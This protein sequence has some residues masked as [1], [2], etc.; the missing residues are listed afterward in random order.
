MRLKGFIEY[1]PLT[2]I[3][4]N[5]YADQE[6]RPRKSSLFNMPDGKKGTFSDGPG[7]TEGL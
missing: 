5:F 4:K 1:C 2:G 7:I 6:G 3:Q